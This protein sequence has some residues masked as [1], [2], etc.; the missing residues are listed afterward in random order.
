MYQKSGSS[1]HDW[2]PEEVN[3]EV[4]VC[5][6]LQMRSELAAQGLFSHSQGSDSDRLPQIREVECTTKR[7][8]ETYH[9]VLASGLQCR[10]SS[11][12]T[13]AAVLTKR[14]HSR[15]PPLRQLQSEA[16]RRHAILDRTPP[17]Q[18]VLVARPIDDGSKITGGR[19]MLL[20]DE[21]G[22]VVI[23]KVEAGVA[24]RLQCGAEEDQILGYGG[25]ED[26]H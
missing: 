19:S 23:S 8:C 10:T 20:A 24:F 4:L 12:L 21:N 11:D 9:L 2:C 22:E 5:L 17:L 13:R 26:D 6:I 15:D 14:Q 7:I 1:E 25:V 16:L 3:F 18:M